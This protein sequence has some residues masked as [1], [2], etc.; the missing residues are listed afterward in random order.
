M[1]QILQRKQWHQVDSC[2]VENT[3][4][5]HLSLPAKPLN[6]RLGLAVLVSKPTHPTLLSPKLASAYRTALQAWS[7]PDKNWERTLSFV[8]GPRPAVWPC[9][10]LWTRRSFDAGVGTHATPPFGILKKGHACLATLFSTFPSN[11]VKMCALLSAF[12]FWV[13]RAR[14]SAR[15]L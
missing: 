10:R 7:P 5:I 2:D 13:F 8:P 3:A 4:K 15:D 6:S 12:G 9:L 11:P 14:S 1:C